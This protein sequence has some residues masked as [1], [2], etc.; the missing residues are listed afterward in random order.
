VLQDILLDLDH[1]A[2]A[3]ARGMGPRRPIAVVQVGLAGGGMLAGVEMVV[4][5]P[6]TVGMAVIVTMGM[7]MGVVVMIMPVRGLPL[8]PHLALATAANVAHHS[9][10]SSLI[11]SSSPAVTWTS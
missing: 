4:V 10:S 9:T 7:I 11:C 1:A 5:M 2:L 3:Q 6:V 8:D